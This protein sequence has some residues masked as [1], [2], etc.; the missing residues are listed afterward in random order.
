MGISKTNDY[1]QI[2]IKM[3]NPSQEPPAS[4]NA[5]NEDLKDKYVLCTLKIK[6]EGQNLGQGWI[7]YPGLGRVIFQILLKKDVLQSF[8][9]YLESW[10]LPKKFHLI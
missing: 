9:N 2:N 8:P 3:P 7:K 6:I 1:I 5:P 10:D 4:S